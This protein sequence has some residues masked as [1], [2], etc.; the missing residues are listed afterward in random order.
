MMPGAKPGQHVL[1]KVTDTGAG[2]PRGLIDKIFDP[3]FTTKELGKGTGLGLST[4]L[5][6]VK[7]H[8][9]V[10]SVYS[11]LGRGT[12]FKIFIP[13]VDGP[14]EPAEPS[15]LDLIHG[16][17]ETVLLVDDEESVRRVTRLVLEKHSYR[18]I[19]ATDGPE[20]VAIFATHIKSINIVL[21]DMMLPYMDGLAVI[22]AIRTMKADTVFIA[23]T[24][25]IHDVRVSELQSLGVT[26]VLS[27]PYDTGT[28]L[29]SLRAAIPTA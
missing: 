28:L 16:N 18:V 20:A 15:P 25:Q 12:T 9:G 19:E 26:N 3:F 13:T 8:G 22:R 14:T 21:T 7:S 10:I 24:G 2:M 1:F 6:I 23:S 29:R 17:N 4:S 27:K 5:G 11:E